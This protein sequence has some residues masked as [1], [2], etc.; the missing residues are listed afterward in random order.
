MQN[1]AREYTLLISQ[2]A[3]YDELITD[4][5][6]VYAFSAA[7]LDTGKVLISDRH[8]DLP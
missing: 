2:F 3:E 5:Y 1:P 8:D 4:I 6:Q 7:V